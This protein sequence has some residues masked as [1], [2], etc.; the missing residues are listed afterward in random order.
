MTNLIDC[1]GEETKAPTMEEIT[2]PKCKEELEIF[3]DET[4]VTC[5]NCGAMVKRTIN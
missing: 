4:E 1:P 5:D 3:S 2:C